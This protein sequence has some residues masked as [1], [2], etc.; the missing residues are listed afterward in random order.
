M[1]EQTII[2]EQEPRYIF[3]ICLIGDGG[4]GKTCIARRLC[5]NT[6]SVNTQLTVGIDFYTYDIPFA[7]NGEDAFVRLSIWDFGGQEQFKTLFKYYING[8]NGIFLV[9][10]LLRM[11]SL[12]KLDW[13]YDKISKHGLD[14]SPKIL[15]GTKLD[16]AQKEDKQYKVDRII[17][18]QFLK[19][20][21]EKDYV[22]TSS[23]DNVNIQNVFIEIVKKILDSHGFDYRK[24]G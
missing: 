5:F 16:L 23:K 14:D 4:V 15:V 18:E 20:H 3:K 7:F 17:V 2:K 13:W 10:D 21:D 24:I 12:I 6:F 1:G 19:K 9:F 11:E 8:A 22:K